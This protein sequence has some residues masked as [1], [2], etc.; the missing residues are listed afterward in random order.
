MKY[1]YRDRGLM[2]TLYHG[3]RVTV[4]R[5]QYGIGR[6]STDYGSGFYCTQS[7]DLAREWACAEQVDGFV[8]AYELDDADLATLDLQK[9]PFT[10]LHWLALLVQ[11]REPQ[12]N[13]ALARAAESYLLAHFLP[14]ASS[15][16]IICGWRADD[17]YFSFARAFLGNQISYAQLKVAMQLGELGTQIV[18]KSPKSFERVRFL[19][20]EPVDARVWFGRRRQR[21]LSA[22]EQYERSIAAEDFGG[23]FMRD[24]ITQRMEPDDERLQ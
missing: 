13:T 12:I 1:L 10:A 4:E 20:T 24:I 15:A 18:I 16:D 9:P 23:V 6:P 7:K 5:P 22:R 19:S 17:S 21:D 2:L 14:G 3:S 8:N 11:N